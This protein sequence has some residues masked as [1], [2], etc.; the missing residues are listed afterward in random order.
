MRRH[1]YLALVLMG[2]ESRRALVSVLKDMVWNEEHQQYMSEG[3]EYR[4]PG[5]GLYLFDEDGEVVDK[6]LGHE[7][8]LPDDRHYLGFVGDK[9]EA[10]AFQAGFVTGRH[11]TEK[12]AY[13]RMNTV[14]E[15]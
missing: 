9:N 12:S 4:L 1:L 13:E 15:N 7:I 8:V 3:A 6:V 10:T 14:Y 2:Q 11:I 5:H